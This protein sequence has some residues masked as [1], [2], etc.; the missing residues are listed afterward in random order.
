VADYPHLVERQFE[1]GTANGAMIA[2]D[3]LLTHY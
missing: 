1:E 3:P 2:E